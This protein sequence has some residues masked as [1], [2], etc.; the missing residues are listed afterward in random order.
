MDL[1]EKIEAIK[2]DNTRTESVTAR[3]LINNAG[4]QKRSWGICDHIVRQ[5]AEQ[6]IELSSDPYKE[7]IDAPITMSH[8]AI[9][10]TN[11][12]ADAVKRVQSMAAANHKPIFVDRNDSLEHAVTLMLQHDYSQLPV[13][14]GGERTLIGYISW[15]T[16]GLSSWRGVKGDKVENFL[17]DKITTI[18][19][20]ETLLEAIEIVAQKEFVIVLKEDKSMSG[21]ITTADVASEFFTITQ[22]EAFLLLEQIELHI[23]NLINRGGILLEDL[24]KVCVEEGRVVKCIDDLT[25]G[26][27]IRIFENSKHWKKI[28]IRNEQKSFVSFLQEVREVRNDVMH[29]EPDG[30]G[31]EKMDTLRNM[32]RYLSELM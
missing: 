14:S 22:A 12:P 27:Y 1:K 21:I 11:V 2:A 28:N 5:L 13:V 26:E 15:K 16:I 8:K 3:E 32:A 6:E 20:T 9:A 25:F 24:Q 10:T 31:V 19:R 29:F 30:I 4:Y 23:R 18:K 7:W 17:S